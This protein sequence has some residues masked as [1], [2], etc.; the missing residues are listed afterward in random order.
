MINVWQREY[1]LTAGQQMAVP[2][3]NNC[4]LY[5]ITT[6]LSCALFLS[7]VA[8]L[9]IA[10]SGD[11]PHFHPLFNQTDVI[12]EVENQIADI[13]PVIRVFHVI[14]ILLSNLMLLFV[15]IYTHKQRSGSAY[16]VF[17]VILFVVMALLL[18]R[19]SMFSSIVHQI[20]FIIT[21]VYC[22]MIENNDSHDEIA[23]K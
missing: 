23:E 12:V 11:N 10:I 17:L 15:V 19:P 20:I 7:F 8:T 2:F 18:W 1:R 3:S 9:L 6:L 21:Y 13:Y 5:S 22:L 4:R 14:L 16:V